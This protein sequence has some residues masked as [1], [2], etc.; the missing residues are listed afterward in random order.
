V[1]D[2]VARFICFSA[3]A[4]LDP[5]FFLPKDEILRQIGW[6]AETVIGQHYLREEVK[7]GAFYP[8]NPLAIDFH[9]S[10]IGTSSKENYKNFLKRR[11]PG[12]DPK[13]ID[14]LADERGR[15]G[16]DGQ[17]LYIPDIMTHDDPRRLEFYE[18]KANSLDGARA[19]EEKVASVDA[20]IQKL[21][22]KYKSGT[23]HLNTGEV[24]I[25]IW[26]RTMFGCNATVEFRFQ[27]DFRVLSALIVYDFC[28]TIDG[29]PVRLVVLMMIIALVLAMI[30]AAI[31]KPVPVPVPV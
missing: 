19:G 7:R 21:G 6:W 31:P 9:D 24:G 3:S 2:R 30:I 23:I 10:N 14:R 13:S 12:V 28:V 22:M 18:I 4:A 16:P 1:A 5:A 29:E 27:R 26:K 20:F 15:K 11:N 25:E 8:E 17:I